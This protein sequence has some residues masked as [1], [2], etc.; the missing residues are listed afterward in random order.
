MVEAFAYVIGALLAR[1]G[2]MNLK[3][4][5]ELIE[6]VSQKGFTEFE[7]ERQGF[8]LRIVSSKDAPA[9][10]ALP[11]ATPEAAASDRELSQPQPHPSPAPVAPAAP[12]ARDTE[13]VE[14]SLSVIRAP[15]PGTFYRSPSPTAEP[16]VKIGDQVQTDTVV[17]IIEAM[18]LMNNIEA[19]VSG[20]VARIYVENGQPVEYGQPLFGIRA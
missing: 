13:P 6:L 8:R 16:F 4:L 10:V 18:K 3:E 12:A 9:P 7:M 19:D 20:E 11:A 17:C 2:G 1:R 5:K 15:M 14:E